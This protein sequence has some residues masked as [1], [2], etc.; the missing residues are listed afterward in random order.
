MGSAGM[1]LAERA[2]S[3]VASKA[4]GLFNKGVS[5]AEGNSFGRGVLNIFGNQSWEMGLTDGG[6]AIEKM[7]NDYIRLHEQ[8]LGATNKQLQAI[9]DFHSNSVAARAKLHPNKATMYEYHQQALAENHPVKQ[10][11]GVL[12]SD[13]ETA[14]MTQMDYLI[15]SQQIARLNAIQG[16]YG[17]HFENATPIIAKMLTDADPRVV[18]NAHRLADIISNQ[19]RDTKMITEFGG[20]HTEQSAAKHEMNK[21]FKQANKVYEKADLGQRIPLLDTEK[22]YDRPSEAERTA[23]RVM[24]MMLIPFV[25]VK[26]IGQVFNPIASSPLPALGAALMRMDHA[27]M[28]RTIDASGIV[29]NTMWRSMYRDIAGE[30]GKLA[31]WTNQPTL[32][33]IMARAT[34]SPGMSL[35]RKF[36]INTAGAIGFH[37]AIYWAHNFAESGSRIAEMRLR[38]MGIDPADVLAQKGKLTQ[39]QL[40]KGVFHFTNN[41]EFMSRSIDNSLYQNRNVIYRAG[42][43]YHSFVNTQASFMARELLQMAKVGDFKGIAQFVGTTAVLFPAIAAPLLGSA[44]VLLRTAS[45]KQAAQDLEDK[46]KKLVHP[47]SAGEWLGNY[48]SLVS[49]LGAAGVYFNYINAIKANRLMSAIA[50]PL[51]GA[52]ATDVTDLV[53]GVAMPTKKG[54]HNFAPLGRDALKQTIPVVGSALAHQLLP[55][56]AEKKARGESTGSTKFSLSRRRGGRRR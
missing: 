38:E 35:V 16:S 22:T 53:H 46:Y 43:M 13:P 12:A 1:N 8:S 24:D 7:H 3:A 51:A 52:F 54:G 15:R 50:G 40:T 6:R 30:T 34:H 27:E 26:H 44:D 55:T 5:R 25:A 11:T 9:R 33:K 10:V 17:R 19:V 47:S 14:K 20:T 29:A 39:E 42:F 18:N 41:R 36:Q 37:S 45:V 2:L 31:E 49:H 28:E 56:E 32:G 48:I 21:A 4:E 23:H